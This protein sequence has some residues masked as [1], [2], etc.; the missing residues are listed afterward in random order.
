[1]NEPSDRNL[2]PKGHAMTLQ[3]LASWG[4]QDVAFVKRVMVNDEEAWAIHAANGAEMGM[5]P[6]R[7][8]AFAAIRQHDMEPFSV[9]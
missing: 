1:M 5:A 4:L 8:L 3:E 9:H 6:R 7:E 2:T